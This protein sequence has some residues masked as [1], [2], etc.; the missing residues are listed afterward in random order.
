MKAIAALGV[1]VAVVLAFVT[2]S[3]LSNG[4]SVRPDGVLGTAWPFLVGLV[5][6]WVLTRSWQITVTLYSALGVFACTFAVGIAFRRITFTGAQPSFVAMAFSVLSVLL[7]GWRL[8]AYLE[9]QRRSL[10]DMP[11]P[12]AIHGP[13]DQDAQRSLGP[14]DR[15][16]QRY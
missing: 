16:S 15:G 8:L 11:V 4:Q 3:R 7:L 10:G 12:S 14:R 1:D 13:R 6:G 9:G 2:L 5:L